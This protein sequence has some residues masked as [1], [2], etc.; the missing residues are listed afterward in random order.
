MPWTI[1][2]NWRLSPDDSLIEFIC[3][4]NERSSKHYTK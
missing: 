1:R 4:E 2:V 3:N